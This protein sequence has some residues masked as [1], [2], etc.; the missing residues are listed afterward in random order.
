M[1]MVMV[2]IGGICSIVA[3]VCSIIVLIHAFQN[4]VWKGVLGLFCGIY[5]LIYGFTE[6]ESDKKGL[7]L[8]GMLGAGILG[9]LLTNFG[10]MQL[11]LSG[12]GI[13]TGAVPISR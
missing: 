8:A 4:T 1:G 13:G 7:I 10:G 2:V 11:G 6:F 5:L 12:P 3:L 9:S